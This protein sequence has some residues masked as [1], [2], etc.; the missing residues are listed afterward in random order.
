MDNQ[1]KKK[2]G[3]RALAAL[4]VVAL[5]LI[6]VFAAR[7]LRSSSGEEFDALAEELFREEIV[8]ST[9]NL[10]YTL[11]CPENFGISDYE[12]SLGD[13][14]PESIEESYRELEE[15]KESLSRFQREKLAGQQ[16]IAYDI[17]MD[18]VETELSVKGLD[19]YSEALGPI[20]GYQAQLPIV[21]AE[22]PFR[23]RRDIED[24]LELLSL[25]DD[26]MEEILSFEREKAEAGL[27]MS[28]YAASA[29][30]EQCGE[31][32][33]DPD[34]NYVIEVF[35]EKIDEFEGL[36]VKEKEEYRTRNYDIV[37]TEVLEGYRTL[38]EGLEELKGSGTNELGL[39]YYEDGKRYYE[40]LV[41]KATGSDSPVKKLQR[42]TEKLLEDRFRDLQTRLIENPEI[43]Y[44]FLEYRF[45]L[46]EPDDIVRDLMGKIDEA[47]PE[48]PQVNYRIKYVHPSMEEHSSPAFYLTTPA[49]DLQNNVIYINRRDMD[50]GGEE[51]YPTLAHEGY[52]GHLYQNIYTGSCQLPLIRNL[53]SFPGYSEGW[54]TYVEY[55]Y[56]YRFAGMEEE[57]ARLFTGNNAAI[58][59]MYAYTDMG[60]HYDG[61][62][63]QDAAEYFAGFGVFDEEIINQIYDMIVEEPGNYLS[64]FIGY[65]EIMDLR[66]KA[67]RELEAEFSEKEFHRFLLQTGPAPFYIIE[68]YMEEWMEAE[69]NHF[70]G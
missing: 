65:L 54:A 2:Y 16:R 22:Y 36:S 34:E 8:G 46:T 63:R 45:P 1:A 6:L 19:L 7:N 23:T 5:A 17:L 68:D 31:F 53:F 25:V 58:L 55:E 10:H 47:F 14:S 60:I 57:L 66:Q 41:R 38:L 64:Y 62:D 40:Y 3:K 56:S 20:T 43:Y 12:V 49:D 48:P 21:L 26:A 37:T 39:C 32:I 13:F 52:P 15:L 67:E 24:Y 28:D 51:L 35:N 11:A 59:A 18:Y 27:F 29:I 4:A 9:I 70:A 61:W 33:A 50:E 44:D 42:S 69:K 30:I